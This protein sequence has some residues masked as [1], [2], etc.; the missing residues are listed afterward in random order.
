[1]RLILICPSWGR[2]C[3]IASYSH[4]LRE[5]LRVLGV[6]SD[7]ATTPASLAGLLGN[8]RHDG[9]L[10][11]HEYGLYYFNLIAMLNQAD[12]SGLPFIITMHNSDH[13]NWM[14]AQHLFLF[15]TR[16]KLVVHSRITLNNLLKTRQP[17]DA[18]RLTIIPMG[19][20]DLEDQFG[21]VDD[22][23]REM[24]LPAG[25]FVV[26]FG[27]F[28]AEHKGIPNLIQALFRL[29]D[30]TG[31]VNAAVHP[32]NPHAVDAI[33]DSVGLDRL[34]G[35]RG[36]YRN[37]TISHEWIPD[38]KFGR[39]QNALDVIVLPYSMHGESIS[40]SM[41]AHVALACRRPTVVTA[42]AYFDDLGDT[43]LTIP[44]DRPETI[45]T[46]IQKL[47]ADPDLRE[48]LATRAASYAAEHSWPRVA[49]NYL[50]LLG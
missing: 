49:Q 4:Q 15:K 43:V 21:P 19:S 3:G 40:T 28:A 12:R 32:V 5:G 13:R 22:V 38:E 37:V 24:G 36:V 50:D 25:G 34:P 23:R 11:Q 16:A 26:G 30:V 47:R 31:Y 14:G 42:V 33:Y 9:I 39:F 45:A 29:P 46:A 18:S 7:V 17:V 48:R 2:V 10:L 44:D 35:E 27:G 41:M 6:E 8:R 20:P 1:V